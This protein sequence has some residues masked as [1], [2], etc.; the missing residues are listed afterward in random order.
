MNL[1]SVVHTGEVRSCKISEAQHCCFGTAGLYV[2]VVQLRP[3]LFV[4]SGWVVGKSQRS[5]K[6]IPVSI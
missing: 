1:T 3:G 6:K 5:E 4:V 2:R